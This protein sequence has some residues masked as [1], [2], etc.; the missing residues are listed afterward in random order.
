MK[1]LLENSE[2]LPEI[3][4]KS[5]DNS[6]IAK[7]PGGRPKRDPDAEKRAKIDQYFSDSNNS[8]TIS[9]IGRCLGYSSALEFIADAKKNRGALGYALSRIEELYE[10]ALLGRGSTGAIF[11]LKQL[12]WADTQRV[13][14]EIKANVNLALSES[15][16]ELAIR[17]IPAEKQQNNPNTTSGLGSV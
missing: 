9:G 6:S 17:L 5:K 11:A 13:E 3:S 8:K 15:L 14:T 16:N 7:H 12:G 10:I 4:P 1:K 2:K